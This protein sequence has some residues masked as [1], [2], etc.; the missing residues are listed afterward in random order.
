MTYLIPFLTVFAVGPLLLHLLL[1]RDHSIVF[2]A[3]LVIAAIAL[4]VFALLIER[5]PSPDRGLMLFMLLGLWLAWVLTM[6]V[7][8]RA[9]RVQ[10][11]GPK[12]RRWSLVIGAVATTIPWFG[13]SAATF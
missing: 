10:F 11:S 12:A 3:A 5:M 9:F 4:T 13:F 6:V 2:Y 8:V 1:R 7:C